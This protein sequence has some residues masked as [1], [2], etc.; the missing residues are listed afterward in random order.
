MAVL[1]IKAVRRC[2]GCALNLGENC[3]IFT[4][5]SLKWKGRTCEGYNNALHI[6]HYEKTLKPAG[7]H[8][9]LPVPSSHKQDK[10]RIAAQRRT[11][12][13]GKR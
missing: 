11:A 7:I 13:R 9:A 2:S 3:A 8:Q 1:S 10:P 12:S 6:A 5:P 4:Y